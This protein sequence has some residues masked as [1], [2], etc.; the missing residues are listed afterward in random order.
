MLF[1]T[2]MARM[3]CFTLITWWKYSWV[4]MKTVPLSLLAHRLYR[5]LFWLMAD[6]RWQLQ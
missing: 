1:G 6:T 5:K 3:K 2:A 4:L